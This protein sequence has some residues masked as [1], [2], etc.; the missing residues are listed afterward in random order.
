MPATP[1]PCGVV[2]WSSMVTIGT[3]YLNRDPNRT[4]CRG[5]NSDNWRGKN[6][7]EVTMGYVVRVPAGVRLEVET[8]NGGIT[9]RKQ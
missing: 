3:I 2:P 5:D 6:H 7:V 9:L 4:S 1:S 8:V